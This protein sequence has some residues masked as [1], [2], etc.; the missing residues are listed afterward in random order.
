MSSRRWLVCAAIVSAVLA[1]SVVGLRLYKVAATP[2][3]KRA[4]G[5]FHPWVY[6][7][8]SFIPEHIQR[9]TTEM[10]V[11]FLKEEPWARPD[12]EMLISYLPFGMDYE[13]PDR[14]D[15]TPKEW[16][17]FGRADLGS[18]AIAVA[19]DRL[20][21][22]APIDRDALKL[23]IDA[24]LEQLD[25]PNKY[26]RHAATAFFTRT[27]LVLDPQIYKRVEKMKEDPDPDVAILARHHLTLFDQY[28]GAS[29]ALAKR[30]GY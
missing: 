2:A 1:L 8:K 19:A 10:G 22:G 15:L 4:I 9:Q 6:N 17:D 28:R 25:A 7:P 24:M 16:E 20:Y 21:F 23:L 18:T 3:W 14:S 5:D 29:E 13:A 11:L 12:V 26:R 27:A 30:R